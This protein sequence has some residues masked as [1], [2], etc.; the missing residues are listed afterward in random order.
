MRRDITVE[1][2]LPYP[3][4]GQRFRFKARPMP[5]WDGIINCSR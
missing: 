3:I 2:T 1:E 5:G 4:A